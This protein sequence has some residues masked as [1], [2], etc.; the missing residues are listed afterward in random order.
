MID[1]Q[2]SHPH[3]FRE[4]VEHLELHPLVIEDCL[5]PNRS[6]RFSSY[7]TS[8]HFEIPIFSCDSID[9]YLSVIC[10]PRMLIT[11][12][13]TKIPELDVL[14]QHLDH[15]VPLNEGTKSALLYAILDGLTGRLAQAAA[16]A[17]DELREISRAFDT[18]ARRVQLDDI[19]SAKR[20]VQDISIVAEDQLYCLA[21]LV[22]VE[23]AALSVSKQREYLRDSARSDETAL[24]V[25]QRHEARAAELHQHFLSSLQA[26]TEARLRVLTIFTTI[27][28]PLTLI[29]GI[30]GMNFSRMP[31]LQFPWA[32]PATL[33][34]MLL[35]ALG[36]LWFFY[37]RGWFG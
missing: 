11:I 6:S 32:Y 35:I 18:K 37:K 17:R 1:I 26:K 28:T 16:S 27:G 2:A 34:T 13:A 23:S 9:Q 3:E 14:L 21:A 19:I 33:A 36:Q 29:A 10:V 25:L 30:Y 5:D 4:F 31:E 12:R 20:T 7:E 22:P 8:L 15:H 24:R